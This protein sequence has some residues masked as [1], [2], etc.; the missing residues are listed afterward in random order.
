MVAETVMDF[1][2][3][4]GSIGDFDYSRDWW[5]CHEDGMRRWKEETERSLQGP[6]A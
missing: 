5:V 4:K 1:D 2:L 3:D 6:S